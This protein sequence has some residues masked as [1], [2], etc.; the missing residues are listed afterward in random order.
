MRRAFLLVA[1]VAI[2]AVFLVGITLL[3]NSSAETSP[4][5]TSP[6]E[7]A[8]PDTFVIPEVPLG[9]IAVLLA[10]FTAALI[11]RRRF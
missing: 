3:Q 9:T 4:P 10:S 1:T 8:P 5:E 11:A 6:P 2:I 7:T